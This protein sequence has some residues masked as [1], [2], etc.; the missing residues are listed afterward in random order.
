MPRRV[1]ALRD[2]RT[3]CAEVSQLE[4]FDAASPSSWSPLEYVQS[5]LGSDAWWSVT[6][7][8]DGETW[9]VGVQ[10]HDPKSLQIRGV[11]GSLHAAVERALGRKGP[12]R[13]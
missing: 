2:P 5:K 6:E 13:R 8:P 10:G 1:A 3:W 9:Q 11:G 4:L 7:G 12:P